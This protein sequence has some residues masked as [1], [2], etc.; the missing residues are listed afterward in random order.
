MRTLA[1]I[2]LLVCGAC[3]PAVAAKPVTVEQLQQALNNLNGK[4][5]AEI[6][7]HLSELQLSE[8]L[9]LSSFGRL[10]GLM[11]GD[12][13]RQA[14]LAI[15]DESAFL[16]PPPSEIPD[17]PTPDFA[18]Q[19][20]IMGLVVAYVSKTVPQLPNFI[21]TRVT[22][23]F[24]DV[25]QIAREDEPS[26][27]YEPMHFVGRSQVTSLYQDNRE[28]EE[29]G[30]IGKKH[31]SALQQGL[32]SQGEFGPILSTILLDA[33][34]NK[35]AWL[36]WEQGDSGMLAVFAYEV[37]REKS[38]FAIDFCCIEDSEGRSSLFHELAGYKGEIA[39]DPATGVI[40]RLQ[41][42]AD[43]K[44]GEPIAS[45]K[46][47]VDYAP[48]DIAGR[49]YICPVH[50][51]ALSRAQGI[52][53]EKQEMAQATPH[54]AYSVGLA[55]VIVG[56]TPNVAYQTLL[57]DITFERYHVF[58]SEARMLTGEE[59]RAE[60]A[61]PALGTSEA[62]LAN[63][64]APSPAPAASSSSD[65]VSSSSGQA[66]PVGT[67][68]AAISTSGV[69]SPAAGAATPSTAPPTRAPE[70][71]TAFSAR[72]FLIRSFGMTLH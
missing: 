39:V 25:P 13:S 54:G 52:S 6:A 18:E 24:E 10:K 31:S 70:A 19:R 30:A 53:N 38:H 66:Q 47:A 1:L 68:Q 27:P 28:V 33:A 14:L 4:P 36:Q 34:E 20:R 58:R 49:M 3:F 51:I 71:T 40:S 15:A 35:L 55:P 12:K 63:S 62:D 21:A 50:G 17:T 8:R 2:L 67:M 41:V 22:S 64:A 59:A 44:P 69:S 7:R 45:A 46:I 65:T 16:A 37:P 5:D 23:R 26:I 43:M 29:T 42:V 60:K 48:V 61:L 11:P 9:S 56:T 32:R 72:Y 57:N